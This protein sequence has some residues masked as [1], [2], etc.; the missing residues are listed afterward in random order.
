[1]PT[2]ANMMAPASEKK[3]KSFIVRSTGKAT[4]GRAQICLFDPGI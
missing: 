3:K 1:M 4:V 2:E